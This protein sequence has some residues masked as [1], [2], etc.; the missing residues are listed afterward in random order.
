MLLPCKRIAWEA[1]LDMPV[2]LTLR[3]DPGTGTATISLLVMG[4]PA[5]SPQAPA[6]TAPR[7]DGS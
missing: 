2:G 5:R 3:H 1:Y 7:R 4:E 6:Q